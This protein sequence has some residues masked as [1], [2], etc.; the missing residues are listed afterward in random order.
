M[1][2]VWSG[3]IAGLLFLM[4]LNRLPL[5]WMNYDTAIGPRP[6]FLNQVVSAFTSAAG[7]GIAITLTFVVAEGLSQMAFGNHPRLW[8]VWSPEAASSVPI[9]SQTVLGYVLVG[10]LFAYDVALY[11]CAQDLLGWWNPSSLLFQP[12]ILAHVA[13]WLS[14][15]VISLRAGFWEECLFRAVPLAGAAPIGDRLGGC[16][17]WI[18]GALVA[19]ALI[20]GAVHA[21]YPAQPYLNQVAFDMVGPLLGTTFTSVAAGLGAGVLHARVGGSRP[22]PLWRSIAGGLGSVFSGRGSG[23]DPPGRSRPLPTLVL[24]RPSLEGHSLVRCDI[25]PRGTVRPCCPC[26]APRGPDGPPVDRGRTGAPLARGRR[27][28]SGRACRGRHRPNTIVVWI[29]YGAVTAGLLGVGYLAVVRHD[30]ATIPMI[31]ATVIG[32]DA[33]EAMA[34][35]AYPGALVG[36]A[37]ALAV[38]LSLGIGWTYLLRRRQA[39]QS[40][41]ASS[42]ASAP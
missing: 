15:I 22:T 23:A 24:L 32:L 39:D 31:G 18:D 4:H 35:A 38:V 12:D 20:F 42:T 41:S 16:R 7:W 33:V 37:L 34:Q 14:P 26:F 40:G 6:F 13:P 9:L 2:A 29:L 30:R 3:G 21:N 10:G 5:A 1:A 28:A 11:L 36:E 17:W 8:K 25:W 27:S 19:Q